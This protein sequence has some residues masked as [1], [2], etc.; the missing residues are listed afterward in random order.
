MLLMACC[1]KFAFAVVVKL[2][3]DWTLPP[4]EEVGY[5]LRYL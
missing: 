4:A 2:E 3:Q 1:C 5:M